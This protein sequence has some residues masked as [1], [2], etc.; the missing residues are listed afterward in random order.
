[1]AERMVDHESATPV[2]L[3]IAA[4]VIED[5]ENGKLP[6][7][8]RIPSEAEMKQQFGVARDTARN[9]VA[10]LREKGYVHTVPQRGTFVLD[11]TAENDGT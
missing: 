5:I 10:H 4:F 6:V 7:G 3:Q 2:Y 1:M 8:R 11:R 9:T